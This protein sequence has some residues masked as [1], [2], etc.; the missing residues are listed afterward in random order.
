MENHIENHKKYD[1]IILRYYGNYVRR[2][3]VMAKKVG[4]K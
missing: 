1:K 4:F 2:G 3:K